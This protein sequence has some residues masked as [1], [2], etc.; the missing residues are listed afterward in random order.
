MDT[1]TNQKFLRRKEASAYLRETFG[2]ERAV[3]T[4][5]KLA[6]VGGGPTFRKV[7]Y[8]PLYAKEDLDTW[9]RSLFG[10]RRRTTSEVE[11]AKPPRRGVS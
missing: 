4:L 2:I 9:A 7:G 8:V 3:T 6:C 11:A 5:A 10:E 1:S